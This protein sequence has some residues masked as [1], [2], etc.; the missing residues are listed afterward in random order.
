MKNQ[1]TIYLVI[2]ATLG[3]VAVVGINKYL[4][5][6]GEEG[7]VET[8]KVMVAATPINPG[9]RLTELNTK[10]VDMDVKS[11]PQGAI[12]DMEQVKERGLKAARSPG[13]WITAEQLTAQ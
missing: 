7:V 4:A 8:A 9:E 11:C 12:T 1:T 3:L 5:A 10:F 6:K 2:A 13:D